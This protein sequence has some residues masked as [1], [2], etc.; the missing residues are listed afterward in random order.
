VAGD[1]RRSA[2]AS[3][4][5]ENIEV[6]SFCAIMLFYGVLLPPD[7]HLMSPPI[8]IRMPT[9]MSIPGKKFMMC[10]LSK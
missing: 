8:R 5:N 2:A 9:K 3:Q 4:L 7:A 6:L 10:W 1:R